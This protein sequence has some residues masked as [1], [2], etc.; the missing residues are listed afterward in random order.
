MKRI[1]L[2]TGGV[3]IGIII[4]LVVGFFSLPYVLSIVDGK[5]EVLQ[6]DTSI[7]PS[8]VN[9]LIPGN[10]YETLSTI[11]EQD[12]PIPEL[13]QWFSQTDPKPI[14]WVRAQ[15]ILSANRITIETFN[16]ASNMDYYQVPY[17]ADPAQFDYLN[18]E[19]L[20]PMSGL[21]NA[22]KLSALNALNL[23]RQNQLEPA[24][25][26]SLAV[27]QTGHMLLQSNSTL[28][29]ALT[30][31]AIAQ[32]GLKS[33]DTIVDE[34]NL[35]LGQKQYVKNYLKA[36]INNT[37]AF[38]SAMRFEY[39]TTK[40]ILS[41]WKKGDYDSMI[42]EQGVEDAGKEVNAYGKLGKSSYHFKIN[43]TIN[44]AAQLTEQKLE[45][46]KNPCSATE[47]SQPNL[48]GLK[49]YITENSVGKLLNNTLLNAT[50]TVYTKQ[51]QLEKNLNSIIKS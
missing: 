1:L 49:L 33:Y 26:Q 24:I 40:Q 47:P 11:S 48:N 10:A 43:M 39:L 50:N 8:K 13:N 32:E 35:S 15:Q 44:E 20:V 4:L 6:D 19:L 42:N 18:D 14:D 3:I 23:A 22:A 51:C 30:G 7:L 25:D 46:V 2:I 45:W 37:R 9:I 27:Y 41:E 12:E 38:D 17:L 28:I 29:Q 5:D 21:R 31:L 34:Y 16:E 36:R